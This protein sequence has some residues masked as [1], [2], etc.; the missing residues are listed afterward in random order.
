MNK[1]RYQII[2]TAE[3]EAF[4]EADAWEAIQ[5]V[6]GTGDMGGGVTIIDC[7]YQEG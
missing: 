3:V 4:D 7:D 5:D 2:V 1:K 6:I